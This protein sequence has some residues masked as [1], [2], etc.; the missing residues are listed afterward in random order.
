M[1]EEHV[2]REWDVDEIIAQLNAEYTGVL[3]EQALRQAQGRR[4]EVK[5]RLIELIRQATEEVRAGQLGKRSGHLLAL[6]LLTEFRAQEALPAILEAVS[7]LGRGPLELFG[8]A[9][10]ESLDGVLAAVATDAPEVVDELIS[11]QSVNQYV[12]WKAAQTYLHWVRDGRLTRDEAVQRLGGHLRSAIEDQDSELVT[13]LVAELARYG[14]DQALD[15]VR[16]AYRQGLVDQF[17]ADLETVERDVREGEMRF[18]QTLQYRRPSVTD[19]VAELRGWAAYRT[20][21]RPGTTSASSQPGSAAGIEQKR[22]GVSEHDFSRG[23]S[24]SLRHSRPRVGRNALCPCGSGKKYK[25][26]CGAR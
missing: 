24:P 15:K 13:G 4:D 16:E 21:N 22:R 5:P 7:L 26:C 11:N 6:F 10:T 18:Q 25:K 9:I 1:P 14:A 8:D 17:V 3:P 2:E 23:S 19:T 12:R 20:K